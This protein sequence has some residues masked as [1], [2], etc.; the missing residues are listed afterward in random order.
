MEFRLSHVEQFVFQDFVPRK[1][2]HQMLF[3]QLIANLQRHLN[4]NNL[5]ARKF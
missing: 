1:Y 2:I 3:N 5:S 4:T